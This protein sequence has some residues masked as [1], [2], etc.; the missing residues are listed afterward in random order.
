[1]EDNDVLRSM[2]RGFNPHMML[3]NPLLG[4]LNVLTAP[5][6]VPESEAISKDLTSGDPG[7]MQRGA[8]R[9]AADVSPLA[10]GPAMKFA[11]LAR[12]AVS[13]PTSLGAAGKLA[14]VT[15]AEV[16]AGRATNIL[17]TGTALG[18]GLANQYAVEKRNKQVADDAAFAAKDYAYTLNEG[19]KAVDEYIKKYPIKSI[20]PKL[21]QKEMARVVA[22]R[23]G[24]PQD[25]LEQL[26]KKE[27]SGDPNAKPPINPETGKPY[28]SAEGLTQ[29]IDSTWNSE[30]SRLADETGYIPK[31]KR[32]GLKT[33]PRYSMYYGAAHSRDNAAQ[34][35]KILGRK[36]KYGDVYMAHFGG[37]DRALEFARAVE[38]DSKKPAAV[39]FPKEAKANPTI[40]YAPSGKPRE[41]GEVYKRLTSGFSDKEF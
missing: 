17:T 20:D 32:A 30:I 31:D 13:R 39:L 1:M 5:V 14:Q 16:A 38:K 9:L 36:V 23:T 22:D 7:T 29:F 34:L 10:A 24:V 4:A 19:G 18:G 25:F 3:T 41:L 40:F 33:D 35:E 2:M 15:P 21:S 37:V 6:L 12:A 27:S 11:G 26:I 28:S 8:I